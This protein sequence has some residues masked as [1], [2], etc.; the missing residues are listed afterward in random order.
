MNA[1]GNRLL[2][3]RTTRRLVIALAAGV[4]LWGAFAAVRALREDRLRGIELP[5]VDTA[6]VDS[7]FIRLLTD[8]VVVARH[9]PGWQVNDYHRVYPADS[10]AVDLLLR[11]LMDTTAWSEQ[12]S[13]NAASHKALGVDEIG[14]RRVRIAGPDGKALLSMVVGKRTND[15]SGLYIRRPDADPAYALHSSALADALL[16]DVGDWRSKRLARVT[17]DSVA[18][19]VLTRGQRT[20]RLERAGSGW[21]VNGAAADSSAVTALLDAYRTLD[22]SGFATPAQADSAKL[23]HPRIAVTLRSKAGTPLF[24][25]ALDSTA[26]AVWARADTATTVYRLDPWQVPRLAPADSALRRKAKPS[27]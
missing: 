3:D 19:V 16:R 20:S 6:R 5:R 2:A 4:A 15:Y 23:D 10:A 7:V 1:P 21:T 8:S 18:S 26:S 24:T 9:A 11:A 12:I 27:K 22:A 13:A 25:L 14:G 17:P